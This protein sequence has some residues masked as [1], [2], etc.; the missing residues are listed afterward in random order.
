MML[1]AC[2]AELNRPSDAVVS[3]TKPDVGAPIDANGN[4]TLDGSRTFEWDA[5]NQLVAVNVGT[6]RSEFTYDGQQRRVRI[7]EKENSVV[8]SDTNVVWCGMMICEERVAGTVIRR[9]FSRGEQVSGVSR[10]FARDHLRSVRDITDAAGIAVGHYS[11]DPYGRR[12]AD[13]G[14][15]GSV[16]GFTGYY[17]HSSGSEELSLAPYRAYNAD[18]GRW[19]SDDPLGLQ[20]GINL[21]RYGANNPVKNIDPLGLKITCSSGIAEYSG[22]QETPCG[23][24]G[25]TKADYQLRPRRVKR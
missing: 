15:A 2:T 18:V 11:F 12:T 13:P 5:R 23:T 20:G 17:T 25:C 9:G 24:G 19:L 14:S 10:F 8:Q 22:L 7:V 1:A 3:M 4:L 6:H 16:E 21:Y